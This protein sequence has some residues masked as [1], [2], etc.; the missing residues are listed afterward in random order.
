[1]KNKLLLAG[2]IV[3]L[4]FGLI[5]MGCDGDSGGSGSKSYHTVKLRVSSSVSEAT[6]TYSYPGENFSWTTGS[7]DPKSVTIENTSLPWVK[8]VSIS[9]KV[10]GGGIKITA[11]AEDKSAWLRA[12]IIVDGKH[13]T[14]DTQRGDVTV[15]WK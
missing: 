12:E 5:G 11:S 1:M 2:I 15:H 10:I 14:D 7:S 8:T 3:I 13:K 4:I 9:N 6:I